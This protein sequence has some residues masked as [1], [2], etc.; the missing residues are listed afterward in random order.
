MK[1]NVKNSTQVVENQVVN[2][3]NNSQTT[4]NQVVKL[5]K[6]EKLQQ[7]IKKGLSN[8]ANRYQQMLAI[9]ANTKLELF[10]LSK[11]HKA[12]IESSV[13][14]GKCML[15]DKQI[16]LLTLTKIKAI[17]KNSEK[18]KDKVLFSIHDVT[19]ICNRI[20]SENDK[21]IQIAKK[22]TK[23]GGTITTKK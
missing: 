20:L 8:D 14:N 15:T 23:Q 10:S 22:V 12:Y 16:E 13:I 11:I 7:T 4:E 17:V 1:T 3:V 6:L 5:S 2:N 9:G 19:L 21:S 18:L